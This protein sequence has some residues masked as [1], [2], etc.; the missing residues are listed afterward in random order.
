M[1]DKE[2]SMS[3]FTRNHYCIS[4]LEVFE[5]IQLL[6]HKHFMELR[7]DKIFLFFYWLLTFL[8]YL[9]FHLGIGFSQ[10]SLLGVSAFQP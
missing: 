8:S 1:F 3:I 10:S 4:F 7:H 9:M 5:Q 6:C 2:D